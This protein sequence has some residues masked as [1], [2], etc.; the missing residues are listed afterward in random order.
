MNSRDLDLEEYKRHPRVL[1]VRF[2]LLFNM[3]EREYGYNQ[4]LK[5]FQSI[6]TSFNCNMTFLQGII[7]KRYD[8]QRGKRGRIM[9]RQE[10]VFASACY[11][12]SLYK[13]ANDHLR[14]KPST[15]YKQNKLYSLSEFCN[16]EW[17]R[18][19]DNRVILCGQAAYRTEVIRFFEVIDMLT[20]V[21]AKWGG[22]K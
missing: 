4:T 13:V 7:N 5:L 22:G 17:L 6:C 21:L 18:E 14:V 16:D 15:I 11:G 20:S 1:E 10:I 3:V 8:I 19:L 2:V 12:E 9:W